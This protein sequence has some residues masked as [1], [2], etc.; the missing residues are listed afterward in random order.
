MNPTTRKTHSFDVYAVSVELI[1]CELK[2][3][4]LV[5]DGRD[6]ALAIQLRKAASSVS[7]NLGEGQ[8]RGGRDRLQLFRIASGSANEVR[9]CLDVGVAWGWLDADRIERARELLDRVLAM[10]WRLTH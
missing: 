2:P 3:I 10:L 6:R 9:A 7:L 8:R 5:L 1:T 4:A